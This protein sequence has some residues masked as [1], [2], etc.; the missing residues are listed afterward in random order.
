VATWLFNHTFG[1]VL[2]TIILYVAEGS[3][4]HRDGCTPACG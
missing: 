2:M 4:R 1:S 3:V